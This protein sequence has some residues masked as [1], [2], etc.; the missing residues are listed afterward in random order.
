[1][2]AVYKE[3]LQGE[4]DSTVNSTVMCM[5][6]QFDANSFL[7]C[8]VSFLMC[9][10]VG[11]KIGSWNNNNLH[12]SIAEIQKDVSQVTMNQENGKIKCGETQISISRGM[13]TSGKSRI[14]VT[15]LSLYLR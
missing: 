7:C 2:W 3:T 12:R 13:K 4:C 14:A 11:H 10:I 5:N 15:L 8:L 6:I 1:M 9:L